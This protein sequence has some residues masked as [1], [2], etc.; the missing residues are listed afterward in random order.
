MKKSIVF[1]TLLALCI[2][3]RAQQNSKQSSTDSLMN[4]LGAD[5]AKHQQILSAF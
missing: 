1:I 2:G 5:S 4:S 3:A